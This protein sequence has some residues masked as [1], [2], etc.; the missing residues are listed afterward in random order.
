MRRSQGFVVSQKLFINGGYMINR[1]LGKISVFAVAMVMAVVFAGVPSKG[2][3]SDI[4]L[5]VIGPHEYALPVNYESFNVFVQY[6]FWNDNSEGSGNVADS[7]SDTF[8]GLTK[9]V[10]FFTLD[11]LPNIGLA[12]EVIQPEV[13]VSFDDDSATGLGDTITG[14]AAWF[15]PSENSTIGIQSF[16]QVPVGDDDLSNHAWRTLTS[17]FWDWQLGKVNIGGNAGLIASTDYKNDGVKKEIGTI[18]HANLRLGYRASNMF[19]PFF[20]WDYNTAESGKNKTTGETIASFDEMAIGAGMMVH[21]SPNIS[22]TARYTR[23][24]DARNVTKT[25]GVYFKFAYVW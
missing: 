9:Y 15:K 3:A 7:D 8:V 5:A 24:I 2:M 16:L 13:H 17:I 10:R 4:G 14:P 18:Y 20:A 11:A 25:D 1:F 12:Y 6:A 21:F 22:M 19:E 23:A